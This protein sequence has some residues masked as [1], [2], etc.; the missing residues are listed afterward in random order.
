MVLR[1]VAMARLTRPHS[2]E[3]RGHGEEP[4]NRPVHAHTGRQAGR[5]AALRAARKA[6][7]RGMHPAQHASH[8]MAPPRTSFIEQQLELVYSDGKSQKPERVQASKT[9]ARK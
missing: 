8:A 5:Q 4:G 6:E 9:S 3:K 1:T 7:H 2:Q